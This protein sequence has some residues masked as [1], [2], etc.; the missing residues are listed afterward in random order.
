MPLGRDINPDKDERA[1]WIFLNVVGEFDE[2]FELLR[3]CRVVVDSRTAPYVSLWK[4]YDIK[5]RNDG[6]VVLTAFQSR[7]EIGVGHVVGLD[8]LPTTEHDLH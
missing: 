7:E 8:D 1:I 6:K 4:S 3:Y 2:G 5:P